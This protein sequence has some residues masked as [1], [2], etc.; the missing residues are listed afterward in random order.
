MSHF[1]GV[2][3]GSRGEATRLG[4]KSSGMTATAASWQGAVRTQ[5]YTGDDGID[6]A[7]VML[8]EWRGAGTYCVLY[9][10]PIS[11]PPKS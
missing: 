3:N 8:I 9:D 4:T 10:G 7:R 11:G 5:L 6:R 2:L 1:Y